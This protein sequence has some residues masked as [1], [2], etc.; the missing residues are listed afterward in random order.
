MESL[1]KHTR[2]KICGLTRARDVGEAVAC[3]ADAI[4]FVF[5]TGSKRLV[6]LATA[7]QLVRLV[8]AFVARVGLFLDQEA[9]EVREVLEHVPLS[10]LQFHG[11]ENARYCRQFGLPYI[12]AVSMNS[13]HAMQQAEA[14]YPDAAALLLDSHEPGGLGGTGRVFDWQQV[15][16]FER[17]LIL[18]GGLTPDN[19]GAAVRQAKPWG[20]DVSSGV[21][22]A[23][24]IKNAE[25][26]RRFIEE[27]KSEYP[28]E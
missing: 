27:A 24:G 7:G 12:K 15:K 21:E 13:E 8:P 16:R 6:D 14:D 23:P 17:P 25:A 2:V 19:V 18:A 5:V 11:G 1:V 20:V 28:S 26:M 22:D 4:G 9:Q 10:L 3:G